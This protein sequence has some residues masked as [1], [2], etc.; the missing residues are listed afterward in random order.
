MSLITMVKSDS[1]QPMTSRISATS[2]APSPHKDTSKPKLHIP[3]VG[4]M[5]LTVKLTKLTDKEI[6]HYTA[7]T[8]TTWNLTIKTRKLPIVLTQMVMLARPQPKHPRTLVSPAVTRS[9]TKQSLD[10]HKKKHAIS[11]RPFCKFTLTTGHLPGS[12]TH[13]LE[14]QTQSVPEVQSKKM[15]HGICHISRPKRA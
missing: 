5:P 3:Q 9:K 11:G 4:K 12:Q 1:D 14:I 6:E 7:C 10:P 2:I 15:Q 8:P 13:S